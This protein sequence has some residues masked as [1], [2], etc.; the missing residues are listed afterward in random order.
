M[1]LSM[2]FLICVGVPILLGLV[3]IFALSRGMRTVR[4]GLKK[5]V[6][7]PREESTSGEV[8]TRWAHGDTAPAPDVQRAPKAVVVCP[9]CGGENPNGAIACAYC[10]RKL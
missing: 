10:G 5:Q 3:L 1:R 9:S 7:E 8:N 4:E 2:G 6:A